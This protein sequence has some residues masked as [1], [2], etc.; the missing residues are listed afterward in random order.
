MCGT[1][2]DLTFEHIPPQKALNSRRAK[3]YTGDECLSLMV[4]KDGRVPWNADG[5]HYVNQQSG[6]GMY[7]L[8]SDCNNN[9]GALYGRDYIDFAIGIHGVLKHLNALPGMNI[10]LKGIEIYPLKIIK[11]VISMFL[12]INRLYFDESLRNFVMDK[13]STIFD[14]E[15]YK[16]FMYFIC[17]GVQKLV[18]YMVK[19]QS[20]EKGFIKTGLSEITTYPLGFILLID[21]P[22]AYNINCTEITNFCDCKYDSKYKYDCTVPVHE[23]NTLLP[24]DFRSK[25]EI[26]RCRDDNQNEQYEP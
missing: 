1:E 25:S 13:E 18:P 5:L 2:T 16:V 20:T 11:Q 10:N 7:S 9:T 6:M 22:A 8:C 23:C 12:S 4:G 21:S 24:L 15:K 3:I 26:L 14:K 17:S 19:G